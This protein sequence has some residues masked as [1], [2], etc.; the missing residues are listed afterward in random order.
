MIGFL[1]GSFD[2]IHLGHINLAIQ[3]LEM[4]RLDSVLFC[5]AK[6]NPHKNTFP[7]PEQHRLSM[8]KLAIEDIPQFRWTDMEIRRGSP[9][10]TFDTIKELK[11]ANPEKE[12]SLLLG[13]DSV[14]KFHTWHRADEIIDLVPLIVG[15]R[16]SSSYMID[17]NNAKIAAAIQKGI[18]KTHIMEISS[19]EIRDRLGKKMYCG[20]LLPAKV[21]DYIH[22]ND[23]YS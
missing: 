18:V 3:L 12:F 7:V 1:G 21:M 10:Y 19:T 17:Q 20:H 11:E 8:I 6:I 14:P 2:P 15:L 23:L 9:S 13:E 4:C 16:S 5:P 22:T